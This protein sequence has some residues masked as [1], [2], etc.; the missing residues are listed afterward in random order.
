MEASKCFEPGWLGRTLT[1][2]VD[3]LRSSH[4]PGEPITQHCGHAPLGLRDSFELFKRLDN[5]FE[6]WTGKTLAEYLASRVDQ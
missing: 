4:G 3:E 2:A 6:A 5:R 1:D